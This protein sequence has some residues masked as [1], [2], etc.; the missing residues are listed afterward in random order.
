MVRFCALLEREA[1]EETDIEFIQRKIV[2]SPAGIAYHSSYSWILAC[3][4][5]TERPRDELRATMAL[6][7]AFDANWLSLQ[8]ECAETSVLID[9]STY[10][11][12]LYQRLAPY[13]GRP[14]TAESR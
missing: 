14:A 10:A 12:T 6:P 11:A 5:K 1:L 8:T 9:D 7:H 2:G 4:G 13:A 3:L